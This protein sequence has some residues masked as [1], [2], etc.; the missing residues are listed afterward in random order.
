M[1]S[2][3]LDLT[4]GRS[5]SRGSMSSRRRTRARS[6]SSSLSS[7]SS[8][9]PRY[10]PMKG[11]HKFSRTIPIN[12]SLNSA[13]GFVDDAGATVGSFLSFTYTLA[14]VRVNGNT[15]LFSRTYN[16]PNSSDFTNLFDNYRIDGVT[17]KMISG[18]TGV[19]VQT[20]TGHVMPW[21][22]V[23][24]DQDDG[25]APAAPSQFMEREGLRV[26]S[27]S[28]SNIQTHKCSPR[29][30]TQHYNG[31]ALSGYGVGNK[32]AFV[33]S[34]YPN[35]EYYGTKIGYSSVTTTNINIGTIQFL[36]KYDMTMK[37]VI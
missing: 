14:G 18:V 25:L 30:A 37:G 20:T 9:I 1:S 22:W 35:V 6:S 16:M 28:D 27:F 21:L 2:S 3:V 36:I 19:G 31:I 29:L 33:D 4:R 5:R 32:Y 7:S 12:L 8:R 34:A 23:F 17:I 26:V 24:N 15:G 11:M 13:L 10:I